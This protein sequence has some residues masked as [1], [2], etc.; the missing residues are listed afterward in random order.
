MKD[1]VLSLSRRGHTA[2]D[3]AR[4]AS[5]VKAAGYEMG[6][7]MM[8][9]LPGDDPEGAVD[10]GRRIAA[11][12]PDFV[13]IYPAVVLEHSPLASWYRK[14]RYT[15]MAL[16]AA[17]SLV[18]DLYLMVQKN[19]IPVIRMGL[20]TSADLENGSV[21]LAG[22]FHPAFGHLVIAEIYRERVIEKLRG[23]GSLPDAVVIRVHPKRIS[24]MGG[25]KNET[26]HDLKS[27][28]HIRRIHVAG[29]PMMPDHH[30]AMD[31]G[32]QEAG[33]FPVIP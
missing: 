1:K 29:D 6:V 26:L 8:V 32:P 2:L 17:V 21:L 4:A 18:K 22:P 5:L 14:G 9:G 10:T 16:Q 13:R 33:P 28:F 7:Q 27:R 3:T 30:I 15:P 11:L 25:L 12:R 20:Q 19:R 24:A 31:V 23:F